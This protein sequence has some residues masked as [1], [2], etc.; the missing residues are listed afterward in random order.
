MTSGL[1]AE[2]ALVEKVRE[3]S[4]ARSVGHEADAHA[5]D[6]ESKISLSYRIAR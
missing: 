1:R 3:R 5:I 6:I 4:A 2:A